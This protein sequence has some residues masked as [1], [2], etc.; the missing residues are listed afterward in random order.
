M[1]GDT[2]SKA[3]RLNAVV[4]STPPW[5]TISA[6]EFSSDY[7]RPLLSYPGIDRVVI[8]GPADHFRHLASERVILEDSS[9]EGEAVRQY[10]AMKGID[11]V[12]RVGRLAK[13]RFPLLSEVVCRTVAASVDEAAGGY[14]HT[15]FVD[16]PY[17]YFML[18]VLGRK[19]VKALQDYP[20]MQLDWRQFIYWGV[21]FPVVT[22]NLT[23]QE[24]VQYLDNPDVEAFTFPRFIALESSRMCNLKCTMCVTHSDFF[25]TSYLNRYPKHFSLEK[26]K[27][28]VDQM[29][30]YRE[31][32]SIAPQFQGE[33]FL[34]PDLPAMI[35]YSRAKK[36]LVG[37]TSNATL[38]TEQDIRL[39]VDQK[40]D[41]VVVSLDGATKETFESVRV[42]ANWEQVVGNIDRLLAVRDEFQPAAGQPNPSPHL[43]LNM[44]LLPENRHE[45]DQFV[46]DWLDKVPTVSI[47]NTCVN[48]V[49]PE[50]F[51]EP[52]RYPCPSPWEGMHILT[53]GDV[54]TCCRDHKYEEVFGNAYKDT[55]LDIW[56]GEKYRN[57]RRLHLEKRWNEI[58][59][60]SRCDS[61]MVKSTRVAREGDLLVTHTPISRSF[62]R[63]V[64]LRVDSKM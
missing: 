60:C 21:D 37:F 48:D 50:K 46:D 42:G 36:M 43:T 45:V 2:M 61:W 55:I 1:M 53:N 54:V 51:F 57:F 38:W 25:D 58:N 12:L 7:L 5:S 17:S 6:Q 44:T 34:S 35:E 27:W 52:E 23:H 49:V 28:I 18:D 62:T 9:D 31:Y 22:R 4:V 26:F 39:M 15:D 29:E 40:V 47:N 41:S 24:R 11:G 20:D 59:I 14:L 56:N 63:P 16:L 13:L 33:P 3:V 8:C 32:V 64:G 19:V 30:P 10:G